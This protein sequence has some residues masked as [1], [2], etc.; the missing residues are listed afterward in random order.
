MRGRT[1]EGWRAFERSRA[2]DST[3]GVRS[4]RLEDSLT[5]AEAYALLRDKPAEAVK[6]IDAALVRDPLDSVAL[7]S[8]SYFQVV[9]ILAQAGRSDRANAMLARYDADVRDSVRR[10]ID[11]PNRT[12]AEAWIDLTAGRPRDA[13]A[14]F[15]QSSMLPDGPRTRC[16]VCIDVDVARAFDRA[17]MPDSAIASFER[18]VNSPQVDL[19]TGYATLPW[20]IRRLGELY[21]AKGDRARATHYLTR[22]VELW[23]DADSDLQPAVRDARQRLAVLGRQEVR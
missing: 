10:R 16:T 7:G 18:F 6:R 17:N 19:L 4:F 5:V 14:K 3:R 20:A 1:A 12:Y 23:K 8:R 11:R 13:V 21:Q 15:R 2:L 9:R 22:F